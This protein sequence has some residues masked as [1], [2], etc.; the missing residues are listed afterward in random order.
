M[1]NEMALQLV[2]QLTVYDLA[3]VGVA[4]DA[5]RV[6]A[7]VRVAVDGLRVGTIVGAAVDGIRLGYSRCCS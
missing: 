3:I 4:V 7:T 6:G 1:N 5:L 2:L